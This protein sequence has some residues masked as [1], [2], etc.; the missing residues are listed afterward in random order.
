MATY[1]D[2]E[3]YAADVS[4]PS[5]AAD[6]DVEVGQ[7]GQLKRQLKGRHMQSKYN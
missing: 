7:T 4:P 5:P 6:G 3:K 1:N 2:K